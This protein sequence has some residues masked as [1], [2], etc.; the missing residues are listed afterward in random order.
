LLKY[1]MKKDGGEICDSLET[2]EEITGKLLQNKTV[3]K[4][5]H[6]GFDTKLLSWQQMLVRGYVVKPAHGVEGE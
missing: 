1:T 2:I 6:C 3:Y 4:C 5:R